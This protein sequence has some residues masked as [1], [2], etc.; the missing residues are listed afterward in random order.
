MCAKKCL[1]NESRIVKRIWK[2]IRF[3]LL[4]LGIVLTEV[5][6]GHAF[7]RYDLSW[8][9]T[10][11]LIASSAP[12]AVT[13]GDDGNFVHVFGSDLSLELPGRGT[14][15][16]LDYQAKFWSYLQASELN[17]FQHDASA[18]LYSKITK[19]VE[20]ELNDRLKLVPIDF[21]IPDY[22]PFRQVQQNEVSA[23]L[24]IKRN[25]I[26]RLVTRM[27]VVGRKVDTFGDR[28]VETE[29]PDGI[30]GSGDEVASIHNLSL[31]SWDYSGNFRTSY[32]LTRRNVLFSEIGIM[33]RS[34][35]NDQAAAAPITTA[36]AGD[37]DFTSYSLRLGSNFEPSR[38]LSGTFYAGIQQ[39]S[40]DDLSQQ[41]GQSKSFV[42][43]FSLDYQQTR[44]LKNQIAFNQSFVDRADGRNVPISTI[45]L[46]S[47]YQAKTRLS[48][49]PS[50]DY[51]S[52]KSGP[53]LP[54][55]SN[56]SIGVSLD[57][58]IRKDL[59]SGFRYR[60]TKNS[61]DPALD[62]F[63]DHMAQLYIRYGVLD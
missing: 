20:F 42:S 52:Y 22:Y 23:T 21:G 7:G 55:S 51:L 9:V 26:K 18:S 32:Y 39:F 10:S 53:D 58:E 6:T 35:V 44:K 38:R 13:E 27:E 50:L 43:E 45:K 28:N 37:L 25:L 47:R 29:D 63:S 49:T 14:R 48:V 12:A 59:A 62:D 57:Y 33:R 15:F 54:R 17:T 16:K 8:F 1:E 36:G 31:D 5:S 46:S 30:P 56:L 3:A 34:F 11:D 60:F 40:F 24:A 2:I 4:P 41:R 61:N 19:A